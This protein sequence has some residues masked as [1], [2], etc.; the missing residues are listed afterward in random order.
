VFNKVDDLGE[1]P[2]PN[3]LLIGEGTSTYLD[4][5]KEKFAHLHPIFISAFKKEGLEEL[6][7]EIVKQLS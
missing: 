2:H 1:K 6:K 3:P 4:Y 7:Q 5:L